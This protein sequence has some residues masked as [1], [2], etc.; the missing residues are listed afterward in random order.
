[1]ETK[2]Y[3][4]V[5]SGTIYEVC[6]DEVKNLDAGQIPLTARPK[7]SCKKCFGRGYVAKDPKRGLHYMCACTQKVVAPDFVPQNIQVPMEKFA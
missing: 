3:Y 4:S 7:A 1:M 2:L 6:A 5:F